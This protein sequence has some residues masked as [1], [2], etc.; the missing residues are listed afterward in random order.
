IVHS[1]VIVIDAN[2]KN[3]VVITGSHNFSKSA[4]TKNDE[5][6]VIVRG[7]SALAQ[8]YAVNIQSVCDNY[9]FRSVGKA[10]QEEGKD[11]SDFMMD[12]KRWQNG[13]FSG[14]KLLELSFWLGAVAAQAAV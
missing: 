10:M 7:D 11:V 12:S 14:D 13:W 1:K 4:S 8:A 3:P 6:L 5:N 9:H 2:G